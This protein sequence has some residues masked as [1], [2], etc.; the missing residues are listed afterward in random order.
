MWD[1]TSQLVHTPLTE[2]NTSMMITSCL[3]RE[4]DGD[5]IWFDTLSKEVEFSPKGIFNLQGEYEKRTV[6]F[7]DCAAHIPVDKAYSVNMRNTMNPITSR[8]ALNSDGS[9][10]ISFGRHPAIRLSMFDSR[11]TRF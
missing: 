7:H 8:Y 4:L 3:D 10:L 9:L 1:L 6:L 11:V 2:W 5:E